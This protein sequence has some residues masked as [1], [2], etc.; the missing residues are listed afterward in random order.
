M[1]DSKIKYH[2]KKHHYVSEHSGECPV[3]FTESGLI[4]SMKEIK[5]EQPSKN[6][7]QFQKFSIEKEK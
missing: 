1:S 3:C 5:I 7:V 2:C 6:I 4:V